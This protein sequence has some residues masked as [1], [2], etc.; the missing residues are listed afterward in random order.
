MLLRHTQH[1]VTEAE[2]I[3]AFAGDAAEPMP[4]WQEWQ[5][6]HERGQG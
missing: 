4:W 1:A 5:R 6:K 3:A 2:R